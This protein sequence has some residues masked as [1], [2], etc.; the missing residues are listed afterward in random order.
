MGETIISEEE[1]RNKHP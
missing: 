1:M